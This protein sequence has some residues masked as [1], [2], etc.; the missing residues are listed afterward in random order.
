M[1]SLRRDLAPFLL[2]PTLLAYTSAFRNLLS[3]LAHFQSLESSFV[4][5]ILLKHQNHKTIQEGRRAGLGREKAVQ[6]VSRV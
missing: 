4:I 5:L 3:L 2:V 1:S 6:E